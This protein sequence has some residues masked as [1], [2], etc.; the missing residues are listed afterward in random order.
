MIFRF[1]SL[2]A[3]V[4]EEK[5]VFCGCF[6]QEGLLICDAYFIFVEHAVEK[7]PASSLLKPSLMSKQQPANCQDA[8]AR[9][10]EYVN[11]LTATD[12]KKISV[13]CSSFFT[14]SCPPIQ[15]R[16]SVGTP[17]LFLFDCQVSEHA[18]LPL[19]KHPRLFRTLTNPIGFDLRSGLVDVNKC[20]SRSSVSNTVIHLPFLH[21]VFPFNSI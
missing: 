5:V 16:F 2:S 1:T 7:D 20:V 17:L 12:A 4:F 19:W 3:G 15:R 11:G 21:A 6:S 18:T 9:D 8:R 14:P 13:I 10:V